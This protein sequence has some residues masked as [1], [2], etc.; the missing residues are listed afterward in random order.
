MTNDKLPIAR[1]KLADRRRFVLYLVDVVD[2]AGISTK[3]AMTALKDNPFRDGIDFAYN[4]K[5]KDTALSLST[6]Q[7]VMLLSD[8]TCNKQVWDAYHAINDFLLQG[9]NNAKS[10]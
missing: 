1:F 4:P 8:G 2:M 3:Q 7:A 6:A 9:L 5:R 10:K